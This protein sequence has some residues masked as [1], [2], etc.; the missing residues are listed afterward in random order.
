[1]KPGR[2]VFVTC[3]LGIAATLVYHSFLPDTVAIHFDFSGK[4]DSWASRNANTLFWVLFFL[5]MSAFFGWIVP[6]LVKKLPK[7]LINIPHRDYWLSAE[8]RD[9][10]IAKVEAKMH[11][12]A[13]GLNVYIILIQAVIFYTIMSRAERLNVP[14]FLAIVTLFIAFVVVWL[15]KFIRTFPRPT[16]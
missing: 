10:T 6:F 13:A 9:E 3:L 12:F 5:A 4:A 15:L 8:R 11:W 2:A 1:M 16:G 7:S 14:I